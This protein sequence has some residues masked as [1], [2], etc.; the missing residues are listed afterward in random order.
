MVSGSVTQ[1]A[2]KS[3]PR[4]EMYYAARKQARWQYK[5]AAGEHKAAWIAVQNILDR[6]IERLEA[7]VARGLG[8]G[9]YRGKREFKQ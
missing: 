9:R 3:L 2:T 7:D 4:L 1:V 8:I 6:Q 5:A